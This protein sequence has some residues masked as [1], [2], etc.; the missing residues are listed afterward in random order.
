MRAAG[1]ASVVPA[2]GPGDEI[3]LVPSLNPSEA[4]EAREPCIRNGDPPP[5][6]GSWPWL[7]SGCKE[8]G[9]KKKKSKAGSPVPGF[10]APKGKGGG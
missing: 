3:R 10:K 8:R 1:P 2:G 9:G 4:V 5:V 7:R 6:R